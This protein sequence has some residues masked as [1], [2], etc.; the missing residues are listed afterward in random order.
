MYNG[1]TWV[2]VGTAGFTTAGIQNP[3]I[4]LIDGVPHIAF[5]DGSAS[6]N[7]TVMK[8]NGN[9]WEHVGP[10]GFSSGDE[11][12]PQLIK[13]N[14]VLYIK[15][16]DGFRMFNGTNWIDVGSLR[17]TYSFGYILQFHGNIPYVVYSDGPAE[18]KATVKR[19]TGNS[20]NWEAVGN[21]AFTSGQASN[22][23][24]ARHAD[25]LYLVFTS[26][27]GGVFAKKLVYT[28][29]LPVKLVSYTALK[30]DAAVKLEWSVT[31]AHNNKEFIISRSTNGTEF[32][33]MGRIQGENN[34]LANSYYSYYDRTP[35]AG[36]NYYKLEQV[37]VDGRKTMLGIRTVRFSKQSHAYVYPNPAYNRIA[38]AFEP[39]TYRRL[40]VSN[41]TGKEL[42]K[43]S[44]DPAAA[45]AT[46]SLDGLPAGIYVITLTGIG[47][48]QSIQVV[49]R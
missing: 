26:Y 2:T 14:G 40:I 44:I 4:S 15:Y 30:K 33:E 3:F 48:S 49:K 34:S 46:I 25:T 19:F 23:A 41:I 11:S 42:R 20:T 32:N 27:K 12:N 8:F 10:A 7:A 31:A 36:E 18:S 16:K 21:A 29:L 38:V 35:L 5:R 37:D 24:M 47:E 45:M 39:A 17:P 28:S 1:S 13:M 43:L 6:W 9:S 22:F